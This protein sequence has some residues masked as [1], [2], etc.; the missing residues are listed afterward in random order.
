MDCIFSVIHKLSSPNPR[1]P[2]FSPVIPSRSFRSLCF[3]FI[4]EI[5]FALNFVK[6]VRSGSRFL[7][8]SFVLR[9]FVCLF[10]RWMSSYTSFNFMKRLSFLSAKSLHLSELWFPKCLCNTCPACLR[11]KNVVTNDD[12]MT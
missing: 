4:S 10:Y 9:I 12:Q 8:F 5:L 11:L 6:G 1:S 3:T 2:R 7:V